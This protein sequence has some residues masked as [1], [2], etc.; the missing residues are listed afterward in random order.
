MN[1]LPLNKKVALKNIIKKIIERRYSFSI[2][3]LKNPHHYYIIRRHAPWAGFFANYLF[4]IAHIKYAISKGYIPVVDMENFP[5]LYNED[6]LVNG[7]LNGWEYYFE[8]PNNVKLEEAYASNNY[9]ISDT[10]NYRAT[11]PYNEGYNRFEINEK[12]LEVF[13]KD[14]CSLIPIKQSIFT[15]LEN[16]ST[17]LND[18][19]KVLGIHVRG[20]DKRK[21]VVDHHMSAPLNAYLTKTEEILKTYKVDKILLCC[22]EEEAVNAFTKKFGNIVF[23]NN[24]FRAKSTDEEG[25]HIMKSNVRENHK[26]L[27]GY[28]VLRDCYMLSKCNYLIF[29]HSN[30]TNI[31]LIWNNNNYEHKCFIEN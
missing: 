3:F 18:K 26:Y 9:I 10:S 30:V 11:F 24:A 7:T 23:V 16:E 2:E 22:D 1:L 21:S 29:S 5:T 8:Q 13:N 4:V 17:I 19:L 14:L 28:E 31:A 6:Y 25:I 15:K 12:K 27:L 20:T